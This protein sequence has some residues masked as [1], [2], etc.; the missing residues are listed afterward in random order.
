[1]S[2]ICGG[3][4]CPGCC[5]IHG[6][7]A[8]YYQLLNTEGYDFNSTWTSC[9]AGIITGIVIGCIVFLAIVAGVAICW[10]RKRRMDRERHMGNVIYANTT[11]QDKMIPLTQPTYT[12][13][14]NNPQYNIPYQNQPQYYVPQQNLS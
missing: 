9:A 14:V 13:P 4:Q 5:N 8:Y 12:Q 11:Q 1:M 2:N 6:S 10:M 7:C 3:Y